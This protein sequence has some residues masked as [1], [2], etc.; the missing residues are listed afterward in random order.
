MSRWR[1]WRG[2]GSCW[3]APGR[4]WSC[5]PWA[6]ATMPPMRWATRWCASGCSPI[7]FGGACAGLGGAFLSVIRVEN[8]IEGTD[9][10]RRLD[11]AGAGRLRLV[12]A[13]ARAFGRMALRGG[14]PRCNC[15]CRPPKPT[16][17]FRFCLLAVWIILL[18]FILISF[19]K[20]SINKMDIAFVFAD[21]L[22][23]DLSAN[24]TSRLRPTS[25]CRATQRISLPFDHHRAGADLV[26]PHPHGP[27]RAGLAWPHLS[28][29]D[30]RGEWMRRADIIETPGRHPSAGG[31]RCR[32][33]H[34]R[35]DPGLGRW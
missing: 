4:G 14:S 11:R 30:L 20:R 9:R 29:V 7:L 15:G 8:W 31:P 34:L 5:A 13:V 35:A 18:A 32:A 24:D 2:S 23:V 22:H 26:G 33:A 21:N 1:W 25:S 16:Y 6:K 27:E 12:E 28:R 10:G 17:P 19:F 3:P